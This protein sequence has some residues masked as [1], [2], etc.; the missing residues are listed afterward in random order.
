[1]LE[2]IKSEKKLEYIMLFLFILSYCIITVFHE[3]WFDEA[4]AWQIAKCCSWKELLFTISH[5][6]GH[7]SLWYF[8]LAIP[9]KAGIPYEIGLKTIGMIISTCSVFFILFK[10]PFPKIIRLLLP[11]NYFIFYQ[12]GVIVRPYGM[13]LLVFLVLAIIFP[14]KKENPF[15]FCFVL[16]ILCM[17]SAYGILMAGGIALCFV[18]DMIQEKGMKNFVIQLFKDY[19]TIALGLL[20]ATALLTIAQILPLPDTNIVSAEPSNPLWQR[21]LYTIL[22][23]P[24]ESLLYTTPWF[25]SEGELLQF[26]QF[27][28][29]PFIGYCFIGVV[30][31]I[32]IYLLSTRG[33][34]KYFFIPYSIFAIFSALKYFGGHHI[35]IPL[36]LLIFWIWVLMDSKQLGGNWRR[37]KS[38][39]NGTPKE[40]KILMLF[41]KLILVCVLFIPIWWNTQSLFK[42]I[43]YQYS[44]GRA[45]AKFL[46]E[47]KLDNILV[48][49]GWNMT[50]Y[51]DKDDHSYKDINTNELGG[52]ST[53]LAYFNHN[54]LA[55]ANGGKND[56]AYYQYRLFSEKENEENLEY[57]RSLPYPDVLLGRADVDTLYNGEITLEEDYTLVYTVESGYIWKGEMSPG[58]TGIYVR[59]DLLDQYNLTKVELPEN[60]MII[61]EELR[62][63]YWE[64][65]ITIEELTDEALKSYLGH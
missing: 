63:Q 24:G 41:V 45:V 59:N 44:S 11:F 62:R 5:Y 34:F 12:Y 8:I 32:L 30:L 39:I 25:F 57:W 15:Q 61:T 36:L 35:G 6:E 27:E 1:M 64:G 37:F 26:A 46:K 48:L 49:S 14:K 22:I 50:N 18:L 16:S 9:A 40:E 33:T 56:R 13:M 28:M 55:N 2:K 10:S 38:I 21:L 20:L 58:L 54:F 60:S 29:Y 43:F 17:T 42:D 65:K 4:Q 51:E 7:P 47:K 31:W 3:P 23:L 53:F 19:R 52:I